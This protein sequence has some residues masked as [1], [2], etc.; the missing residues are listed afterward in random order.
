M[1][2]EQ[3]RRLVGSDVTTPNDGGAEL[4]QM[5]SKSERLGIVQNHHVARLHERRKLVHLAPQRELVR[6]TLGVTEGS[7]VAIRTVKE[8]MDPLGDDEKLIV[9]L[10]HRPACIDP[11]TSQIAE[12][13][14][15]HFGH[16]ASRRGGV[17]VP[18]RV[19][20]QL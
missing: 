8:V 12:Y 15:E 2:R 6:G 18:V 1:L 3:T 10:H 14:L 4:A 9:T 20:V 11:A 7:A 16:A 5:R 19:T 13:G 17:D